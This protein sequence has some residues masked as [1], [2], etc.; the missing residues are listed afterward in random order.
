[1]NSNKAPLQ[2]KETEV[3]KTELL[4]S[5]LETALEKARSLQT[6]LFESN[7]EVSALQER[8]H[9]LSTERN[10]PTALAV[11]H[12]QHLVTLN[13]KVIDISNHA[14]SL[15]KALFE[16]SFTVEKLTQ[17]IDILSTA[18]RSEID[19]IK[20][21]DQELGQS[22]KRQQLLENSL[23]TSIKEIHR[24]QEII[25]EKSDLAATYAKRIA[26][27]EEKLARQHRDLMELS[28]WAS[29][30]DKH[31][32]QHAMRRAASRILKVLPR[33][34]NSAIRKLVLPKRITIPSKSL[35]QTKENAPPILASAV[36]LAPPARGR[37]DIFIF[38]VVDWSFR[39]QRPQHIARALAERGN[40]VFFFSNHFI[41]SAEVGYS[42]NHI[43]SDLEL[44]EIKLNVSGA[45]PIYFSPPSSFAERMISSAIGALMRDYG[46][47]GSISIIQHCYWFP[48]QHR[49]PDTYWIY[50]CMDHH[51]GFGNVPESLIDIEKQLLAQADL[52]TVTSSWL[53]DFASQYCNN[54]AIIRNGADFD[55][56]AKKPEEIF[57]DKAKRKIIGYYGA[58]ADWFD[59][60]LIEKVAKGHPHTLVLL[61]GEDTVGARKALKHLPNVQF[62][63]EVPYT[64]LPFYLYAFDVCLLPFKVMPL[65][66]ATNPVKVYEYLSAGKPVVTVNLPEMTQFDG[67]VH[68]ARDHNEFVAHVS[69]VLKVSDVDSTRTQWQTY[70]AQQTWVHRAVQLCE[71]I[72]Q[73]P[74]PKIS[75]I[76]L[77]YN[78]LH[79]TKTCIHSLLEH[80]NY[81]NLEIIIVDNA[82]SDNT[83]IYLRALAAE[84]PDIKLILNAENRGF[85]AGNNQG[86]EIAAGDYFVILNN[87][88]HVTQGWALTMLRHLLLDRTIGIIG[89]ITNNIG[90]EARVDTSY[91]NTDEMLA[92]ARHLT[93]SKMGCRFCLRTAAFF[94]AMLPRHIYEKCGPLSEDFG[95]GFFEDDDYC[96]R[97][98]TLGY[99]VA[100]ADDVFVHHELSASFSKLSDSVRQELFQKNKII[101]E[102]KWGGWIPHAYR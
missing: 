31:P 101:Y 45:P 34:I 57:V 38:S 35:Q 48:I 52:I 42:I 88:T 24:Q 67:I 94:C 30:I 70:A 64:R 36:S 41:D 86:L 20:Q 21:R 62:T 96:R 91:K 49:I 79:L 47:G 65:T 3:K 26:L 37:A 17:Y 18:Y 73:L 69:A 22:A 4:K 89:P 81:P 66:L 90:N 98:E 16:R 8:C 28:H 55:F 46:I 12:E 74:L 53:R 54:V 56:F 10:I 63:G 59:L 32:L 68:T 14:D 23:S 13:D 83:P 50:D 40:R 27:A 72:E 77:T 92:E 1:M 19:R 5:E 99:R 75:V 51:E 87:D 93:L 39:I 78:N 2:A 80:S 85:A 43:D 76:V 25:V 97:I 102:E 71:R 44:Y 7:V 11:Q 95:I 15:Q 100:C 6:A 33:T 84:F 60:D 58:I 9:E 82:S 29:K 61:I